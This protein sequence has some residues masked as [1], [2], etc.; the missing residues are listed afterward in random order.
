MPQRSA[1]D[2]VSFSADYVAITQKVMFWISAAT[3]SLM[4]GLNQ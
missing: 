2:D 1:E 3:K 4:R